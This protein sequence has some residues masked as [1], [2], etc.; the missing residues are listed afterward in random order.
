MNYKVEKNLKYG[1]KNVTPMPTAEE[2]SR[3][4]NSNYYDS[5][6]YSIKYTDE[7][8]IHKNILATEIEFFLKQKVGS[9]LDI[10]CGEGFVLNHFDKQGWK[11]TGLDSRALRTFF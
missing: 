1:F 3:F 6:G 2:L 9:I 4:Y 7:E 11:V 8:I 10:G 5:K